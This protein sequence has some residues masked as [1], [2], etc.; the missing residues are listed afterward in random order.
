MKTLT[1]KTAKKEILPILK[2]QGVAKAAFFGSFARGEAKKKSD[3]DLLVQFKG[4]KSLLDLVELRFELEKKLGKKIDLLTYNS[5][6]PRLRKYILKDQKMI[7]G[8][9]S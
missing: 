8:K 3:V 4:E 1:F 2:R 9:R 5:I 7:Y 6:H